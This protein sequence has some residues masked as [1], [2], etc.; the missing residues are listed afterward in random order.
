MCCEENEFTS[1]FPKVIFC[2]VLAR[3]ATNR[4]RQKSLYILLTEYQSMY[5]LIS[6]RNEK[7]FVTYDDQ[8]SLTHVAA[9][10]EVVH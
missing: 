1:V 7:L 10:T 6:L 5:E 8:L 3:V 4:S 2:P 9:R